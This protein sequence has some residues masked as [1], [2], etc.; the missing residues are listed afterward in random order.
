MGSRSPRGKGYFGGGQF[1]SIVSQYFIHCSKKSIMAPTAVYAAKGI[2]PSSMTA[3][4]KRD[5]SIHNNRHDMQGGLSSQLFDHLTTSVTNLGDE[6]SYSHW[7]SLHSQIILPVILIKQ[8][9]VQSKKLG[10]CLTAC[11][12]FIEKTVVTAQ[13][14][15]KY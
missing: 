15:Q 5:H 4:S 12:N 3:N 2:T 14:L 7:H 6:S 1:K 10:R 11:S 8:I 9:L 13:I